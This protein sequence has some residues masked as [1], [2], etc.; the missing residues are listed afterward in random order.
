MFKRS[1]WTFNKTVIW[2]SY[3]LSATAIIYSPRRVLTY[4]LYNVTDNEALKWIAKTIHYHVPRYWLLL[5]VPVPLLIYC[6]CLA[7][8]KLRMNRRM[9]EKL[10]HLGLKTPTGL[11]PRVLDVVPLYESK[12]K[13]VVMAEGIDIASFSAKKG[14]LEASLNK[15]VQDIGFREGSKQIFEIILSDKELPKRVPFSSVERNLT[16]PYT[17]L[18]GEAN[19]GFLTGDLRELHHM[20]IAGST[21]GGKSVFFKQ[22]LVGL[23]KSS[24][25]LH[26]YLI[27]LKRGVEM[28]LFE[29]LSNVYVAKE[30]VAA[31]ECLRRMVKEMEKRFVYLEEHDFAEI[32]PERDKLDR[33]VIG[34]DEASVLFTVEKGV[35]GQNKQYALEARELSDK[36]TKLGRAAGIH[37]II[38]TQ[39][40]TKETVDTR[41]QTNVGG[42]ICFRVNTI[43]SS[44]NVL[45]N[46]RAYDLPDIKGRAIWSVGSNDRE[47][48]VPFLS[49]DDA[50]EEVENLM[51]ELSKTDAKPFQELLL[52]PT[53]GKKEKEENNGQSF[54]EE[55]REAA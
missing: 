44:V 9:E 6:L 20:L 32:V 41:V 13:L 36:I 47:V 1:F 33:L 17:F 22:A 43:P 29:K 34:I 7:F 30:I 12:S 3:A 37:L 55:P 51:E 24:P 46:R 23:L 11:E 18:V 48:Q 39:K 19:S 27:D 49:H 28:K 15:I 42:K 25:H 2:V 10:R 26:L 14:V 5:L 50:K 38:A 52:T 4:W 16:K 45:G 31:V 54:I 40:I 53:E 35:Q 8:P 21:G